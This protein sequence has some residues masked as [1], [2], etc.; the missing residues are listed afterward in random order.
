LKSFFIKDNLTLSYITEMSDY[1]EVKHLNELCNEYLQFVLKDMV[2]DFNNIDWEDED[3][4]RDNFRFEATNNWDNGYDICDWIDKKPN[5]YFENPQD[6]FDTIHYINSWYENNYGRD[7]IMDWE[8]ICSR[9]LLRHY[10]YVYAE[11]H[12]Q[13]FIEEQKEKMFRGE[14]L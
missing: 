11:E 8:D 10:A 7:S 14:S 4:W 12:I 3:W 1:K 13:D 9:H 5:D 2:E 6:T